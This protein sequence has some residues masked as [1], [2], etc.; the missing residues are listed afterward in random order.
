MSNLERDYFFILEYRDSVVDIREQFPL[1]ELTETLAIAK[2]SGIDHP[3]D[4]VSK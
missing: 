1:F 2:E 4:P 3:A